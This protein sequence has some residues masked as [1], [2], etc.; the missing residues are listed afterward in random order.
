MNKPRNRP[1]PEVSMGF[2][3]HPDNKVIQGVINTTVDSD[4][5]H[6]SLFGNK[7]EK[8]VPFPHKPSCLTSMLVNL[9]SYVSIC[10]GFGNGW[11]VLVSGQGF[12]P[13]AVP[14]NILTYRS[15]PSACSWLIGGSYCCIG[16][17]N[18]LPY[19]L[20]YLYYLLLLD[21]TVGSLGGKTLKHWNIATSGLNVYISMDVH[22]KI[23]NVLVAQWPM[24]SSYKTRHGVEKIERVHQ[25]PFIIEIP[26]IKQNKTNKLEQKQPSIDNSM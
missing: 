6:T 17:S 16:Y 7:S 1:N 3:P 13:A 23:Y 12:V 9:V 25:N 8:T 10:E 20:V 19:C 18:K 26:L 24:F 15:G 21:S 2:S 4:P 22:R 14:I 5:G 11:L